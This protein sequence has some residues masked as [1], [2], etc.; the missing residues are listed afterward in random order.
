[1]KQMIEQWDSQ[2]PS[3]VA[4][5]LTAMGNLKPSHLLDQ[6]LYDFQNNQRN[7]G[8]TDGAVGIPAKLSS[9]PAVFS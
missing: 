3:R 5:I 1:M 7:A 6:N 9:I 8:S 4:S 2:D